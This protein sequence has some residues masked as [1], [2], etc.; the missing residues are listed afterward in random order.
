MVHRA[1]NVSKDNLEEVSLIRIFYTSL[2][3]IL[4]INDKVSTIPF[5]SQDSGSALYAGEKFAESCIVDGSFS[6]SESD[7]HQRLT[8]DALKF[9]L[10]LD[11]IILV[12]IHRKIGFVY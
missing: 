4:F 2:H 12:K 9:A 1:N 11:S 10:T 3:Y 5:V 6:E 7:M 8:G